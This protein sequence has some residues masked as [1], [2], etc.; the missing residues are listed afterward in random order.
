M[1]RVMGPFMSIDASGTIY[2]TLTA[3]IAKGR[4]YIKGYS[5]PTY[6]N[7]PLQSAQRAK[8]AAAVSKWQTLDAVPPD[9]S[10][11]D[12]SLYKSKWNTFGAT[13]VRS[14]SGFNAFVKAHIA[15]DGMPTIPTAPFIGPTGIHR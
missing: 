13:C 2:K 6:T 11:G 7:T 10:P 1:A 8:M 12:D 3:S 5:R 9:V 15:A 4:N 14:L